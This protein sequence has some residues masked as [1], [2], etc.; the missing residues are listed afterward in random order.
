MQGRT[1]GFEVVFK[2]GALSSVDILNP[3]QQGKTFLVPRL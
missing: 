1:V 2:L 3:S